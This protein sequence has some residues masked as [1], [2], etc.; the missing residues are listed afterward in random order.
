MSVRDFVAVST[1]TIGDI[2]AYTYDGT[3]K[4]PE[5]TVT[6][7]TSGRVLTKGT[8]YSLSYSNNINAG[9]ATVTVTG[10][11]VYSGTQDKS[12]TINRKTLTSSEFYF[13]SSAITRTY[14]WEIGSGTNTLNMPL[15]CT[16]NYTSNN[17]SVAIVSDASTGVLLPGGTLST[18]ATITANCTGN[19]IG[20]ASYTIKATYKERTFS[21][22]GGIQTDKVCPGVYTLEAWGAQ[23]GNYTGT[24]GGK[25]GYEKGTWTCTS[26]TNVYIGVGGCPGTSF[27]AGYN[28]GGVGVNNTSTLVFKGG[29]GGGTHIAYGSA[30][31]GVMKNYSG[32]TD[33]LLVIAGGGG[34]GTKYYSYGTAMTGGAGGG[35][36]IGT[37]MHVQGVGTPYTDTGATS[38]TIGEGAAGCGSGY[39][40]G[41]YQEYS[42]NVYSG[43]GGT[44]YVNSGLANATHTT[45]SRTGNGQAKI[46]WVSCL[47]K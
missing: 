34:A 47:P 6:D 33:E 37:V 46:T 11:G 24:T 44:G 5:P 29:G 32:Y 28:G 36:S 4:Q 1:L 18:D 25:G 23:G 45:G 41:A 40:S 22:S 27:N 42:G 35:S 9:T 12:F 19:Y 20:T 21:Y 31:R 14:I 13:E 17:T 2:S 38:A 43:S 3:A 8:H 7:P 26:T 16:V 10:I 15:D 30:N 39:R